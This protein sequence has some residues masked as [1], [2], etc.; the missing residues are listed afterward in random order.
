LVGHRGHRGVLR[1]PRRLRAVCERVKSIRPDATLY[2]EPWTG[3]GPIH[4]GKGAQKGLTIA[5]FNDHLRNAIRGDL[6]GTDAAI[7]GL[8]LASINND[9]AAF[10]VPVSV[11]V[12]Y[13][14]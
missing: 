5:V 3:G 1:A 2:G 7:G 10:S 14:F 12:S 4:F 6:D 9:S 13:A 11:K 8:G